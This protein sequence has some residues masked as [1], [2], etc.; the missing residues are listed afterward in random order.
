MWAKLK[1]LLAYEPA[2][3]AWGINGG[4]AAIVAFLTPLSPGA[5]AAITTITTALAA[6]YTAYH[7]RPIV[8][9]A[10]TGAVATILTA[11]AAFGLHLDADTIGT[12]V[13]ALGAV[14][15]LMFRANLTPKANPASA[16]AK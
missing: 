9:S 2:V 11:V 6:I 13:T 3:L 12:V 7:A 4:V 16:T 8:V 1:G 14:L 15:G 5:V 10:I